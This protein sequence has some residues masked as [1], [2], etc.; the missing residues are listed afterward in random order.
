MR[1]SSVRHP[2]LAGYG[3]GLRGISAKPVSTEEKPLMRCHFEMFPNAAQIAAYKKRGYFVASSR[4]D[5]LHEQFVR[6]CEVDAR[7]LVIIWPPANRRRSVT[8]QLFNCTTSILDKEFQAQVQNLARIW[9]ASSCQIQCLPVS[10]VGMT[11][12]HAR[13]LAEYLHEPAVEAYKRRAARV[14]NFLVIEGPASDGKPKMSYGLFGGSCVYPVKGQ[15]DFKCILELDNGERF[16]G[17]FKGTR[18]PELEF[19]RQ[20]FAMH[21]GAFR[22]QN[23]PKKSL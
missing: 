10:I 18:E 17:G 23:A 19:I 11:L 13:A 21:P 22:L 1:N 7:P 16:Q 9:G 6:W 3:E 2:Q 8:I 5:V 14:K 12:P 15:R 4:S 20:Q